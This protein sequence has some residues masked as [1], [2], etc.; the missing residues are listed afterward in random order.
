MRRRLT[1]SR[2]P[3]VRRVSGAKI[4]TDGEPSGDFSQ[5][6]AASPRRRYATS[7]TDECRATCRRGV[8]SAGRTRSRHTA[9]GARQPNRSSATGAASLCFASCR[10]NVSST[11]ASSVLT[12]TTSRVRDG[13]CHARMSIEP[14]SPRTAKDTSASTSQ[15]SV[16]S[17]STIQPAIDA[18]PS[19]SSRSISPPRQRTVITTSAS[20]VATKLGHVAHAAALTA[21]QIILGQTG[22]AGDID[23]PPTQAVAQRSQDPPDSLIVHDPRSMPTPA[24]QRLTTELSGT[25]SI[26]PG[27]RATTVAL[28]PRHPSTRCAK[29]GA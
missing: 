15:P 21:R 13:A 23:L 22:C 18:W 24:W 10:R 17:R 9:S 2:L 20:S 6:R 1:P 16:V 19:S 4:S 29:L 3:R 8:V 28:T 25:C 11:D 26:S 14:R 5:L 27:R 7:S 12:S